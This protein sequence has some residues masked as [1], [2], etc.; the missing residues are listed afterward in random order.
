MRGRGECEREQAEEKNRLCVGRKAGKSSESVVQEAAQQTQSSTV[1]HHRRDAARFVLAPLHN[2]QPQEHTREV[3]CPPGEL[4]AP[5]QQ[6]AALHCINLWISASVCVCVHV[7]AQY[8]VCTP[9]PLICDGFNKGNPQCNSVFTWY[10]TKRGSVSH[11]L[12]C[13]F[14]CVHFTTQAKA[15]AF[16]RTYYSVS[17]L[18]FFSQIATNL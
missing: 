7:G 11:I 4:C 18:L 8:S 13:K 5:D 6:T 1:V 14:A 2:A 10:L 17:F 16:L 3:W 12:W 15:I 9:P